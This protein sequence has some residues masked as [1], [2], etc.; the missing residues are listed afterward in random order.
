MEKPN[1]SIKILSLFS[2]PVFLARDGVITDMNQ[3]AKQLQIATGTPVSDL[4]ESGKEEFESYNGGYLT[5]GLS[6]L[7]VP[8]M[9]VISRTEVGDLIHLQDVEDATEFR[10]MAL[11]AQ[12]LRQPLSDLMIGTD[13][14]FPDIIDRE[15]PGLMQKVGKINR[16]LYQLLREV[17]NLSAT[18]LPG[19]ESL[20]DIK[21]LFTEV[22]E[23]INSMPFPSERQIEYTVPQG[24]LFS[25]VN[26]D[27]LERALHNM[28]SN[29]LKFSPEGS[30]ITAKLEQLGSRFR[31]SVENTYVPESDPDNLFFRYLRSPGLEDSRYGI[32]LG[33]HLIQKVA[34]IHN[35]CLLM[36]HPAKDRIRFT[37]VLP[38]RKTQ[39]GE[40]RS[41]VRN[42]DY[43]GGRDHSL[44]ELSDAL[45]PAAFTDLN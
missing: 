13:S 14:L 2:H 5:L 15:D 44:V 4:L 21:A 12:R 20:F 28:L 19:N 1:E 31:L 41:L 34:F 22:M 35:G 32:G 26:A 37:V 42:L 33:L 16:S 10:T 40:V 36:D 18:V 11:I 39:P 43:L 9:A 27:L 17:T 23:R 29:S 6:V 30:L 45:L 24:E 8:R 3:S 7:G 38:I 25:I